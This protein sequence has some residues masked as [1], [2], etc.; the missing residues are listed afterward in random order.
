MTISIRIFIALELLCAVFFLYKFAFAPF[1]LTGIIIIAIVFILRLWTFAGA[2]FIND[3][4]Y[5]GF[6]L[7]LKAHSSF[8]NIANERKQ[9]T[10]LKKQKQNKNKQKNNNYWRKESKEDEKKK[11]WPKKFVTPI[12]FQFDFEEINLFFEMKNEIASG[13]KPFVLLQ[14]WQKGKK[15]SIHCVYCVQMSNIR[16]FINLQLM[17]N[18]H[19]P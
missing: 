15:F 13:W 9:P 18:I 12:H 7:V 8:A 10:K 4:D 16:P 1:W 14:Q 5:F 3:C 11:I 17:S 6:V 19:I 2:D